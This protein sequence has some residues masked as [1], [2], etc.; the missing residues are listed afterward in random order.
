M[1][2]WSVVFLDVDMD[3]DRELLGPK[4]Y[5]ESAAGIKPLE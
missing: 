5:V 4:P 1:V 2:L 3:E